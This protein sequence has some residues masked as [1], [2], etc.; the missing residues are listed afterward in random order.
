MYPV[1]LEGSLVL[2]RE[3]RA[4]DAAA[5][6]AWS[7]D[8]EVVRFIPLGPTTPRGARRLVAGY[9]NAATD[10][11]RSEYSLAIVPRVDPAGP[12]VGTV[13][14]SVDSAVHRRGEVGYA[15]RRDVWGR[16][17]ATDAVGLA[18]HLGFDLLGLER[19]WAVCDP[20]NAASV[21]V[22]EKAGLQYEGRLRGDLI[23]RGER[24]DSLLFAALAA[25]RPGATY[26]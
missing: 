22:L 21:R 3:F 24:R 5:V 4:R 12:P 6:H 9:R 14:L 10:R 23:V 19:I 26:L 15:L 13:A 1:A 2:L 20:E 25:D 16:G 17:Y 11:P 7:S 8:L 18:L